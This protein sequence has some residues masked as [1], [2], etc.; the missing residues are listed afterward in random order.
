MKSE[1][2]DNKRSRRFGFWVS[3][4]F[5]GVAALAVGGVDKIFYQS[6]LLDTDTTALPASQSSRLTLID[7]LVYH[8]VSIIFPRATPEEF[9]LSGR[10]F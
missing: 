4:G 3:G 6:L 9:A 8:V 10:L 7:V 1:W 2:M 5:F